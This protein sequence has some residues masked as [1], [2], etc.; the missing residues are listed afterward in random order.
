MNTKLVFWACFFGLTSVVFGAFGA[1]IL[2]NYLTFDELQSFETATSYQL[3]HSLL[4]L[5]VASSTFF[6]IQTVQWA[7]RFLVVGIFLFSFSIYALTL[8][9][10]MGIHL[11]FL[12]PVTPLGGMCLI[13]SWG[14]LMT[15]TVKKLKTHR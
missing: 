12:G 4:L 13:V 6:S 8:D 3:L 10:L 11:G 9:H 14:I 1:H 15:A 2:E 7:G 5:I